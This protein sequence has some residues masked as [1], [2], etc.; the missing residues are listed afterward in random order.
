MSLRKPTVMPESGQ[1]KASSRWYRLQIF[2]I[3]DAPDVLGVLTMLLRIEGADV[4]AA[5]SLAPAA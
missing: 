2:V 3:E 4:A 1:R 5:G